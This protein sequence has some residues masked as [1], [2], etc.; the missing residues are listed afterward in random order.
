VLV[1][2]A[3]HNISNPSGLT[4]QSMIHFP[5]SRET[6]MKYIYIY[7]R[8]NALLSSLDVSH[9]TKSMNNSFSVLDLTL[10]F[11]QLKRCSLFI[12]TKYAFFFPPFPFFFSTHH[13][14]IFH[15]SGTQDTSS[16]VNGAIK[17]KSTILSIISLGKPHSVEKKKERCF[18]LP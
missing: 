10:S 5:S 13:H 4:K 1:F 15:H 16:E 11:S 17:S 2:S 7:K 3:S 6:D 18:V 12:S 8:I 14:S 9:S